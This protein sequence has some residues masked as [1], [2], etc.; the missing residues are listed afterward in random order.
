MFVVTAVD[1]L[2]PD[3]WDMDADFDFGIYAKFAIELDIIHALG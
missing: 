3:I 1:L 2:E